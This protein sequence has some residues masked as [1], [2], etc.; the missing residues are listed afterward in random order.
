MLVGLQISLGKKFSSRS[1]PS[2][3]LEVMFKIN[4]NG[5]ENAFRS[6]WN[7]KKAYSLLISKDSPESNPD[8]GRG[9]NWILRL[10]TTPR[11]R[12]WIWK[13]GHGGVQT[14]LWRIE[15]SMLVCFVQD[16][17]V[18]W[19]TSDHLICSSPFSKE[20]WACVWERLELSC[21]PLN[22]SEWLNIIS[23]WCRVGERVQ[24]RCYC[25][26]E[27]VAVEKQE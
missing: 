7:F 11:V 27:L 15:R 5:M 3:F 20:L 24:T 13:I 8:V 9:W 16:A 2:L 6:S 22:L 19:R 25:Q 17:M 26:C 14:I 1:E 4:S 12:M 21:N 18:R 10:K 23:G